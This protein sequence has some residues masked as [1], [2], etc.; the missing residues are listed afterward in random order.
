MSSCFTGPEESHHWLPRMCAQRNVASV[1]VAS[2][3]LLLVLL[4]S[5]SQICATVRKKAQGPEV[6]TKPIKLFVSTTEVL[7]FKEF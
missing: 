4:S 3:V 2:R 1:H 6:W 5:V 7:Q